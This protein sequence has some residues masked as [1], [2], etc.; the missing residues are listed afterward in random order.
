MAVAKVEGAT[1]VYSVD[2][3]VIAYALEAGL[4]GYCLADP[5]EEPQH[6][7]PLELSGEF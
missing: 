7:L 5:P 4:E 3:N 6:V 1:A 2:R